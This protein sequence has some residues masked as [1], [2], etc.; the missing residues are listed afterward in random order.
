MEDA[1]AVETCTAVSVE[2]LTLVWQIFPQSATS[3]VTLF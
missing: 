3:L 1:D 2:H